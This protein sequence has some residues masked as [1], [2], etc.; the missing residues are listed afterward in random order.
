MVSTKI[1]NDLTIVIIF[2]IIIV[3]NSIANGKYKLN[4]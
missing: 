4:I 1:I 3:E 2:M